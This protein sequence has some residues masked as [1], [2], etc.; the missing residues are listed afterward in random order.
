MSA[1]FEIYRELFRSYPGIPVYMCL[2]LFSAGIFYCFFRDEGSRYSEQ[3]LRYIGAA[4]RE[5][6]LFF[7]AGIKLSGNQYR[8]C[9][10][11]AAIAIFLVRGLTAVAAGSYSR[12]LGSATLSIAIVYFL[13]PRVYLYRGIRSPFIIVIDR[14]AK[15]RSRELDY[16]LYSS[17]T[18][19]KN[20]AI[21]QESTP[22]SFD[23]MLERLADSSKKLRPIFQRTLGIYRSENLTAAMRYFSEAVGT[24]NAR[25]LALILGKMDR[26]KPTELKN[27]V[28]SFQESIAEEMFTRGLEKAE[29]RGMIVYVL[30]TAVSFV[31]LLNFIFVSVL[32]DTLGMLGELF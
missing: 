26:I 19:L 12:L 29:G 22:L 4:N 14:M 15:R 5:D 16:E 31:C 8:L 23:L 10:F 18:M 17:V 2:L 30:A 6:A 28:L 21:A 11:T 7:K 27:Q 25:N 3:L 24:K 32:M 9:L 20:L 13:L 1:F